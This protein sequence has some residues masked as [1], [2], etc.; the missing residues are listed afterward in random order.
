MPN[1]SHTRSESSTEWL[2]RS[3]LEGE[4]TPALYPYAQLR[5]IVAH[6]DVRDAIKDECGPV[7]NEFGLAFMEPLYRLMWRLNTLPALFTTHLSMAPRD[8]KPPLEWARTQVAT[9]II[10]LSRNPAAHVDRASADALSDWLLELISTAKGTTDTVGRM[11]SV[12]PTPMTLIRLRR[13]EAPYPYRDEDLIEIPGFGIVLRIRGCGNSRVTAAQR[14]SA[15][16]K[17]LAEVIEQAQNCRQLGNVRPHQHLC[18]G[19]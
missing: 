16:V 2:C 7:E 17:A 14:W 6:E 10:A 19:D 11:I 4:G 5:N 1:S 3:R 8:L 12:G 13:P 18:D 15:A 9:Q